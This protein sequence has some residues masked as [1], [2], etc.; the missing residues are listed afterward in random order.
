MAEVTTKR[1]QDWEAGRCEPLLSE[2]T[3]LAKALDITL[4]DLAW[5]QDL[6]DQWLKFA[7][8]RSE[9]R[10][11]VFRVREA[12]KGEVLTLTPGAKLVWERVGQAD[13]AREQNARQAD[14]WL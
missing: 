3:R 14:L 8:K 13:Q 7:R 2:A 12:K 10:A 6:D 4:D 1:V 9:D 11:L 5:E